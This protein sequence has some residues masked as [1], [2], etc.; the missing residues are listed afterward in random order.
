MQK[1]PPDVF[2]KSAVVKKKKKKQYLQKHLC[3]SLFLIQNITKSLRAPILKNI[4]E[5]LLI[6]ESSENV[7]FHFMKE[8][9]ENVCFYFMI[10]FLWSLYSDTVF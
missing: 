3:W 10:G 9:S 6:K 4:C 1:Q 7:Y 5:R 8:A 2:Y